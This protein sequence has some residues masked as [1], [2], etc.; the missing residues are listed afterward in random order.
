M[1]GASEFRLPPPWG[2]AIDRART[3]DFTFAGRP[4]QGYSGD[5]IASALMANGVR[6]LSRS[7]K[8]HRP[9]GVLTMAGLD[10]HTLV[11]IG[12]EPNARADLRL[13]E[14]GLAV[15]AQNVFGSLNFDV[16][17]VI[18]HIG[19]LLPVGFYYKAFYQPKGAWRI[20][21][22]FIRRMAGLG[23]VNTN[24]H[25]RIADTGYAFTDVA[26]IGAGPSGLAAALAAADAGTNVSL[27]EREPNLGGSL[28]YRRNGDSTELMEKVLAHSAIKLLV[29]TLCTGWFADNFLTLMTPERMIKLR[30]RAVVLATGGLDQPAV[31]RNNDL[32]GIMLGSAVQRLLRHYGVQ[33]GKRAVVFA[34]DDRGYEVAADLRDA[35][36]EVAAIVDPRSAA[37]PRHAV[38]ELEQS[39]TAILSGYGIREARVGRDGTVAAVVVSP[40]D[41][42]T[43]ISGAVETIPCDLASISAGSVPAA[44]LVCHSGGRLVFDGAGT[45]LSVQVPAELERAFLAGGVNGRQALHEA[46]D[47]G[48]RSGLQAAACAAG[49]PS[50][51]AAPSPATNVKSVTG[52]TIFPHSHGRDFIDFDEDLQVK[53]I[54][55]AV[56]EGYDDL[57]LVKRYTTAVMGPSQG[58]QSAL[59]SLLVASKTVGRSLDTM[60][61]TTQRPPF[62]PEPI[63]L[64]AGRPMH[65][66]R[67]TAMHYRHQ[68]LGAQLTPAG[69]WLRPAWYGAAAQRQACIEH[70]INAVRTNVGVIDVSTLGKLELRGPD[71]AE[72]MNRVYT[73]AYAIQPAGRIRYV[74]MTDETGAIIDDG[75]SCRISDDLFYV[76]ATSSGVD[77]VYRSMLR[78]NAQWRL[79]VTISNFTS[80]FAAVNLAGPNARKVLERLDP[81]IDVAA[82]AFPY[83]AYRE[84]NV[85]DIPARLLRVGFVG[86]LGYEIHVPAEYGEALWDRIIETGAR[87][88]IAPFGVE[89]QRAL[90]LEKGHIIVGQDTDGLTIPHHAAMEWAVAAKKPFFIGKRAMEIIAAKGIDRRLAGFTIDNRSLV[91]EECNLVIRDGAIVGRVTSVVRS[92]SCGRTIGLAYVA[93]EQTA[94]GTIIQIKLNHG[95]LQPAEIVNTPFYDP[96]NH[97]QDM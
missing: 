43:G 39:A 54:Q 35:G 81:D 42:N 2:T 21:E 38:A 46:L 14:P 15:E 40:F 95:V 88:D 76:T 71:A 50:T 26:V 75:V 16:A 49:G 68:E 44:Q 80:G 28:T 53:D 25:H 91:P 66:L 65:P 5:T 18:D 56:A 33:P 62:H 89:A 8:Y 41:R 61:L 13:I 87:F 48:R 64:L 74:L 63:R 6:V 36:I 92:I 85:A 29:S 1:S 12:N 93:P 45:S 82:E 94:A 84:G 23:R 22:P 4:Y 47:D 37:T 3:I 30:A 73:F 17:R 67:R 20:W 19:G 52:C 27:I 24:G 83:L 10:G 97:R 69:S 79:A 57:E 78:W 32:P 55:R 51:A 59:N 9:R 70:E 31:F 72:F 77:S 60:S 34:A 11:Q 86:E 96:D 58:K 90:R 7:F